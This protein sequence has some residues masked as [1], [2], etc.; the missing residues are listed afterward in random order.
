[1]GYTAI[2]VYI[3]AN[4]TVY[5]FYKKMINAENSGYMNCDKIRADKLDNV[6]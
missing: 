2:L 5:S 3:N 1:M 6:S 4:M